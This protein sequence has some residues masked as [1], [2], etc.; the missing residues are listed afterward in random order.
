MDLGIHTCTRVL[1][2]CT[3]VMSEGF[4][5]RRVTPTSSLSLEQVPRVQW[6]VWEDRWDNPGTFPGTTSRALGQTLA[7][8][9]GN[10]LGKDKEWGKGKEGGWGV[11]EGQ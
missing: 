2:L 6:E 3:L 11:W 5:R 9:D 1:L 4:S 7:F 10:G 8:A